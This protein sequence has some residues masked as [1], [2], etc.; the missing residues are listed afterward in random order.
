[1]QYADFAH[2][3]HALVESGALGEQL[4]YWERQLGG[5][6]PALQLPSDYERPTRPTFGG[7]TLDFELPAALYEELRALSRRQGCT[8][9]MTLLAAFKGL[10]HA[11]TGQTDILVG[12]DIANRN[13][14][15]TE[16]LIGFFV[17]MLVLRTNLSG[18]P[19]FVELIGRVRET[20]LEA[21]THQD[22]PFDTLV[23]ALRVERKGHLNPL[24]QTVFVLQNTPLGALR[25]TGL[26]ITDFE[27]SNRLA[28]LDLVCSL[29]ETGGRL[30]GALHYST[31]LFEEETV[32]RLLSSYRELLET[33]TADPSKRLSETRRSAGPSG[34]AYTLQNFEIKLSREQ[35]AS[36]LQDSNEP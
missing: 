11:Y 13:R 25:L 28:H 3:Q 12:T 16:G 31:E 32:S 18:D 14:L 8:L 15:E 21:Y 20:A 2:W 33:M 4:A 5:E 22:V 34:E 1:M 23:N 7:A 26:T 36:L 24:F 30:I 9:F 19:S 35:L 27:V 29:Q 6:L 10:L 17:N